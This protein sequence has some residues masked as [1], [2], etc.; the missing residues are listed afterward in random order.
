MAGE[1]SETP[2]HLSQDTVVIADNLSVH[3]DRESSDL[4]ESAEAQLEFLPPYSP[5]LNPIERIWSKVKASLRTL[6][7]RT[8]E[9]L[10]AAIGQALGLI[11]AKDVKGWFA[12]CGYATSH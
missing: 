8:Q 12:T 9:A 2:L 7:A 6:K 5:E 11:T 3:K 4:I 1:Y 10:E